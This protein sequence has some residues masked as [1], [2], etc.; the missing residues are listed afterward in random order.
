MIRNSGVSKSTNDVTAGIKKLLGSLPHLNIKIELINR[1]INRN[2]NN[3][4]IVNN[5]AM[6]TKVGLIILIPVAIAML[7]PIIINATKLN[8]IVKSN[9]RKSSFNLLED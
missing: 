4:R 8:K 5:I 3:N 2:T 6:M 9:P 7:Y 1:N